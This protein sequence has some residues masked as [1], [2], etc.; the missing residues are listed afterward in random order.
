MKTLFPL[1]ITKITWRAPLALAVLCLLSAVTA[2][3]QDG[4]ERVSALDTLIV[5]IPFILEGFGLNLLMSILAM[6]IATVAGVVLGF[7]QISPIA[8]IRLPAK[9]FTHLFRNSPWLVIL[10]A[11]M[12]LVP[13]QI[14]LPGGDKVLI[15]DWIKATIGFSLPVMANVAEILR[16]AV[17][18]IPSGQW[19]SAES[20]AFS[21]Y[22]TLRYIILPQC[23][24]RMLPPWMNWYALLTLMTPMAAIL[25]VGDALGHTQAAMEAAGAKPEFLIPFY[26]F[27]MTIFFVFIYPI[28]IYTRRL[29]RR[30]AAGS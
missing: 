6:A 4:T 27:L 19:E 23:I 15:P 13:F 26:L 3:A 22:Q 11:I 30:F 25:G 2:I 9:L 21:R 12:L 24:R 5:W 16:G 8:A 7:M 17:M 28:S 10:F 20:L 14:T 18:S 29:E 1:T